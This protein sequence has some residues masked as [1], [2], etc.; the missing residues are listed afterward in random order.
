M[1]L[2]FFRRV[3]LLFIASVGLFTYSNVSAQSVFVDVEYGGDIFCAIKSDNS[4]VCNSA[5][6]VAGRTPADLQPVLD[7]GSGNAVACAV[8]VG[9]DIRC[10]G[11]DDFG[12]LSPPTNGAPYKSIGT[13]NSH[14]C[15]INKDD[16][17][18]CWGLSSNGRLDAPAGSFQQLSVS[19]R[20]ACAVDFNGA[21]ACWGLNE[22]GSTDV[23]ADLPVAQKVAAGAA[24][25]C[26]LLLD[27]SI[28]CWGRDLPVPSA[29]PFVDL[30]MVAYGT[31]TSGSA[32]VCGIDTN[33]KLDCV[34]RAYFSSGST[35][36]QPPQ[37]PVPTSSGNASLS[38]R[39]VTSGCY[40][41]SIGEIECFG[42]VPSSVPELDD[43]VAVPAT[44]GL[45]AETYSNTTVELFWDA[46]RDAFNVAG[47][48]IQRNDEVVA[49]TQNGSSFL[50]YDMVA[51]ESTTFAVRRVS[52]EGAA[53][54]FSD[55]IVVVTGDDPGPET[56]GYQ[57]PVR[58][59]EPASLEAL[60]Y[61]ST[62]LELVWERAQTSEIDG[63]E[64]RRNG[65]FIGFTSGTSFY[66]TVPSADHIYTYDVIP[67]D[68]DDVSVFYGFSSISV[69]LGDAKAEECLLHD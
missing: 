28:Q 31:A 54:P 47:Y 9:G 20:Q 24:S 58:A 62:A 27:G 45:R 66:D 2:S 26:A 10:W 5:S 43:N 56:D 46:A 52:T 59:Y 48:E 11:R 61:S 4:A 13:D 12:L 8:L 32:G 15:A 51:G 35:S 50:F 39:S 7:I 53:G 6:N 36:I 23:P 40:V 34:F 1:C 67:V 65:E 17:I 44:T 55:S 16:A 69:G 29:G 33:G 38:M 63:Y 60:V 14:S 22:E 21:V 25:S 30:A 3:V 37:T 41:T 19:I 49:F 42:F 57:P 18:E 68:R 64:I